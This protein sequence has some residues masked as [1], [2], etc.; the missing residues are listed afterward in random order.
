[1]AICRCLKEHSPPHGTAAQYLVYVLP[2]GYPNAALICGVPDCPQPGVIWLDAAEEAAY[3]QGA[4]TFGGHERSV[5]MRADDS[6][7]RV[8][9]GADFAVL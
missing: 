6:G 4:R 5:K 9:S 3:K 1:M 8:H 2:L 7:I